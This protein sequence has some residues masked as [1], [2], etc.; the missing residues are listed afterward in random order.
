MGGVGGGMT[1]KGVSVQTPKTWHTVAGKGLC[2]VM[3][4]G[5]TPGMA[6][7]TTETITRPR[8]SGF[9]VGFRRFLSGPGPFRL[10]RY[11]Q[12]FWFGFMSIFLGFGSVRVNN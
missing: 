10:N 3:W 9:R 2:G 12:K 1:Y 4:D 5:G 6:M 11:L 7:V 8:R